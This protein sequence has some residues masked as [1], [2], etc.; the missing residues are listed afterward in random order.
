MALA[1][2]DFTRSAAPN[3]LPQGNDGV[4]LAADLRLD[5]PGDPL[6]LLERHGLDLPDHLHGDFALAAWDPRSRR[7]LCARDI[8][9]VRPLCYLHRPTRLFAFASLPKGLHGAGIVAAQADPTILARRMVD[10]CAGDKTG[11][12]D[13]AWL[14]PGHSLS[15]GVN[16]FRLHRAWTPQPSRVGRW[17]GGREQASAELRHLVELAV[18]SRLPDAGPVAAHLSGGLDSSAI[19]ILAAR[20][21]RARGDQLQA[22]S[23]TPPEDRRNCQALNGDEEFI[24]LVLS[25][26]TGIAWS[27]FSVPPLDSVPL[28]DSDIVFG[29][30]AGRAEADICAAA[31]ATGASLLLSGAGGDE[32]ATYSG[33]RIY[34]TLLRQGH[35]P[36]LVTALAARANR[37]QLPFLDVAVHQL[38]RPLVPP[39]LV[40]L[41]RRWQNRPAAFDRRQALLGFLAPSFRRQ[42]MAELNPLPHNS[43]HPQ[44]R[45]NGFIDS[46]VVERGNRWSIIGA[47]HGIAYSYPLLD[48]RIIDFTLSLPLD[49]FLADGLSRQ[50]FRRAMAGI[51]PD[52]LR[53]RNTKSAPVL[54][55][56]HNLA[57][58]RAGLL[59]GLQAL[60]STAAAEY[61]DFDAIAAA[62]AG[63]PQIAEIQNNVTSFQQRHA[64]SALAALS[65]ARHFA[66][67]G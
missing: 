3:P 55:I 62:I 42:V 30:I 35:W 28:N 8:M 39:W 48:R 17:R 14:R 23:V 22:F 57:A 38:L 25:Q 50:P 37:E 41:R 1:V 20:T 24:G 32:G 65:L 56:P 31:A 9:G 60:R 13:I 40:A 59:A 53:W 44:A 45:I 18:A 4:W 64:I 15:V 34:V 33:S 46:Y 43:S 36:A 7:L 54:D 10:S 26:E 11:F 66:R 2:L 61:M 27:A 5:Q 58:N 52:A 47:R 63:M 51:L 16:E 12:K 21:L 29:D 19:A 49:H 6:A 67:L